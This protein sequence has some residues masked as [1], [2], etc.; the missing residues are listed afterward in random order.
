MRLKISHYFIIN[1]NGYRLYFFPSELSRTL[2]VDPKQSHTATIFFADYLKKDDIVVDIGANIGTITLQSSI[3]IGSRGKVYSIEP[4]P[5]IFNFLLKNIQLNKL[6]NIESFNVALGDSEGETNFSDN[7]SDAINLVLNTNEG[8]KTKI[9]TLDKLIPQDTTI[10][11]LKI[12]VIGYEKFVLIGSKNILKNTKCV[13]FPV[14]RKQ[15]QNFG[16]DYQEIFD[17]LKNNGFELYGFS[18][19]KEIWKINQNYTSSNEDLLAIRNIEEFIKK[20]D[21]LLNE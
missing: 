6:S 19:E 16:Y 8:I 9:T 15:F 12:D 4:N 13:H 21:Y 7:I 3:K 14:I 10:D 11:L 1:Q 20:T 17:L 18:K 5:K 2:W